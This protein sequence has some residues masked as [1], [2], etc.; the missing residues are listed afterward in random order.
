MV[1]LLRRNAARQPDDEGRRQLAGAGAD[2]GD[3][4]RPRIGR[5]RAADVG[6]RPRAWPASRSACA[7]STGSWRRAASNSARPSRSTR[8]SRS[9]V[10]VAVRAPP[11]R[12]AISPIGWPGPSSATGSRRPVD[13][14][15][16]AA[17]HDH[18]ERVR[19]L[20]LAHQHVA[21]LEV[22]RLELGGKPRALV[23]LEILRRSRRRRGRARRP[24]V[25]SMSIGI[26]PALPAAAYRS[27][28]SRR[29]VRRRAA[30]ICRFG[31]EVGD[32]AL[33]R[34]RRAHEALRIKGLRS[35]GASVPA[36]KSV[37]EKPFRAR[38]CLQR[39]I[40][41][42]VARIAYSFRILAGISRILLISPHIL[43]I[44]MEFRSIYAAAPA[45]CPGRSSPPP[46]AGAAAGG[47]F[48]TRKDGAM[49]FIKVNDPEGN[50]HVLEAVEGW[51]V[52]ELIREHGLPIEAHLRRRLR[53]RHLPRARRPR[54]GRAAARRRAT[55]RRRC[56]TSCRSSS[57]PRACPAS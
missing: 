18:V 27:C 29:T 53:L 15:R 2:D 57:R 56:S 55:T 30:C 28:P 3:G 9:A 21:A 13:G 23:L 47:L 31:V 22:Q 14:D 54:L 7:R 45:R 38:R 40:A 35:S 36:V 6:R 33:A 11:A 51:R 52:M 12:K 34:P 1:R 25:S 48:M 42:I 19:H 50:T 8:L 41:G 4:A 26:A 16:E 24:A 49:G 10:T 5:R 37:R 44:E 20:A 46:A 43:L 32:P 17:G 39:S